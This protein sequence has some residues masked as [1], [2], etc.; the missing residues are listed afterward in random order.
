MKNTKVDLTELKI[1]LDKHNVK[2]KVVD[3]Y[4]IAD[5]INLNN[6]K[7]TKLPE[8]FGNIKCNKIGL[9]NNNLTKLPESFGN[10]KCN[11]IWLGNN[12]L[13]TLPESIGNIKCNKI[14][15]SNN[16]LTEL[17]ESIGNIK[18]NIIYLSNNNLTS[19][20]ESFG[21]IKC[22]DIYL[23]NNKLTELPE[24]I[25]NIKCNNIWLSYN[26]LTE[27][28]NS[29]QFKFDD[30]EIGEDYINCDGIFTYYHSIKHFKEYIIYV[31]YGIYITTKDNKTFA[32][33]ESI[34]R[35]ISDLQFKISKR[36]I[37]EYKSLDEDKQISL[38]ECILMYRVITG[39]CSYGVNQFIDNL[40]EL[41]DSYSIREIK[42][43]IGDSYGSNK[44]NQFFK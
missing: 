44:F 11:E 38:E 10:I 42:D 14:Y 32:H 16:N 21:N 12:K 24:S 9:H 27:Y 26:K 17:P 1:F 36:D 37:S 2:Y 28:P 22:N 6:Y 39:A 30:I 29:N 3:N 4:I 8:S 25:G 19:L 20:P 13:I 23:Y 40:E 43:I 33:G 5:D 7:L 15:L 35:A 18:C 41:K 34:R 31:G